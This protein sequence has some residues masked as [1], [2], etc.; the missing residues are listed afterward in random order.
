[1][2]TSS[3]FTSAKYSLILQEADSTGNYLKQYC[4]GPHVSQDITKRCQELHNVKFDT[5][6]YEKIDQGFKD[7]E[8]KQ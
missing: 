4:D 7:F 8:Q 5:V 3:S 2:S 6:P 1:M